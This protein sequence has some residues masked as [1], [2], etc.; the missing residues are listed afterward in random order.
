MADSASTPIVVARVMYRSFNSTSTHGGNGSSSNN[1]RIP[2]HDL[3]EEDL[4]DDETP[5]G[6]E[7]EDL[8]PSSS[9]KKGKKRKKKR[10]KGVG[11]SCSSGSRRRAGSSRDGG[12]LPSSP[13]KKKV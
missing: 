13:E 5:A 8:A 7:P 12:R 2:L 6:S 9:S 4:N 1:D 10:L 3:Q 11:G